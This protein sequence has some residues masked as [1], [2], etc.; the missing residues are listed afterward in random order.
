[1]STNLNIRVPKRLMVD[2]ERACQNNYTNKSEVLR[3]AMLDY[4]RENEGGNE[5][6]RVYKLAIYVAS[7][8]DEIENIDEANWELVE[9]IEGASE[10]ECL[11]KAEAKYDMERHHWTNP[12]QA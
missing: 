9:I 11:E 1:M 8:F 5:M 12:Y 7:N 4:V 2:F 10:K 3:R 6:M